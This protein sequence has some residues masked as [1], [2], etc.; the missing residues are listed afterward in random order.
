MKTTMKIIQDVKTEDSMIEAHLESGAIGELV[1]MGRKVY[2]AF[3]GAAYFEGATRID[4]ARKM[5]APG[6]K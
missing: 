5:Y 2:Y 1:R 4:V 6:W 3:L